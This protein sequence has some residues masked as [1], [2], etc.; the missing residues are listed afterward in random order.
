MKKEHMDTGD[1]T[2]TRKTFNEEVK[3]SQQESHVMEYCL[4]A[5]LDPARATNFLYSQ[6]TPPTSLDRLIEKCIQQ[7]LSPEHPVALQQTLLQFARIDLPTCLNW[8]Q[9]EKMNGSQVLKSAHE[10]LVALEQKEQGQQIPV[11]WGLSIGVHQCAFCR[12]ASRTCW[13]K[14]KQTRRADEAPST[15][16]RCAN[17]NLLTCPGRSDKNEWKLND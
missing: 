5:A 11:G 9:V 17:P 15:F 10:A 8:I 14:R 7:I 2:K 6:P 12:D 3:A 1:D 16:V 4:R 13:I